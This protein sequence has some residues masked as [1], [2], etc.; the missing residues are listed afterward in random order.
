MWALYDKMSPPSDFIW[1]DEHGPWESSR[2]SR[3]VSKWTLHYMGRRITLQD[4]RH[5]AVAEKGTYRVSL[6]VRVVGNGLEKLSSVLDE[7]KTVSGE[8]AVVTL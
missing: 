1:Y 2:M 7:V 5:V 3:A 6:P 4:W 8:K